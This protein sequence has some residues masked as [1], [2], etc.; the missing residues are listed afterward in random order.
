VA[1]TVINLVIPRRAQGRT[2]T[3]ALVA[4]SV[5]SVSLVGDFTDWRP[6]R[7]RLQRASTGVWH[8]TVT[9]R[10]GQYRFAYLVDNAEWRADTRE[11]TAPDDFGRPTS[12][13]TVREN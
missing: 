10:P 8:A 5:R 4:P 1:I 12:V 13:V 2:I 7:V 3:F 9:L 6:D 11:A